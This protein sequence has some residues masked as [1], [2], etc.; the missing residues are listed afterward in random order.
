[1]L[2]LSMILNIAYIF[3]IFIEQIKLGIKVGIIKGYN[4]VIL[5]IS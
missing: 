3:Y 2:V 5:I 1:M 4:D